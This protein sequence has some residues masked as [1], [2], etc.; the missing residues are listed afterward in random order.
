MTN[1]VKGTFTGTG[2]SA[3][4][5]GRDVDVS[6]SGAASATVAIERRIDG[7]NWVTI[8]SIVGDGERVV[9]NASGQEMRLECTSYTSGTVTY[10]M[11]G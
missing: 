8:E 7:V 11:M 3:V 5:Q 9:E 6:I 4:L 10:A 2:V 1:I